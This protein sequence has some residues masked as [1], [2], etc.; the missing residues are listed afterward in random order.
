[1]RIEVGWLVMNTND[2]DEAP[3]CARRDGERENEAGWRID[4]PR[5]GLMLS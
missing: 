2:E 5:L 3:S 4:Q 1:M